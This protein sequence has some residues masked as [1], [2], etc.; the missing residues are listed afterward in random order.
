MR[1]KARTIYTRHL[2]I[3][4]LIILILSSIAY[5][6]NFYI[7]KYP[8]NDYM[9]ILVFTPSFFIALCFVGYELLY[10]LGKV[11]TQFIKE[12]VLYFITAL[13]IIYATNAVQYTPFPP[14]DRQIVTFEALFN[15][16]VDTIVSWTN[17]H[18]H[19][20]SLLNFSYEF[21]TFELFLLPIFVLIIH[22]YSYLREFCYLLLATCLFGFT[23]YYFFPT[24]APASIWPTGAFTLSQQATQ[25]K[26]WQIHHHIPPTTQ[27]GGM[28]SMPSFHIIWAWL[29]TYMVRFNAP[30]F[31][32]L[33]VYNSILTVACV[34][35]G[36]HY[37]LDIIGSVITIV[38][39]HW[40]YKK[41]TPHYNDH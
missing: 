38:L 19:L 15:I 35:L 37:P 7:T 1:H 31:Y 18:P 34:L 28:I 9:I 10:G 11:P 14:I 24:T 22:R 6:F 3:L 2:A 41:F 8:G 30:L 27:E 29:C 23:F 25:L 17:S 39:A 36:W 13:V 16:R 12:C 32:T 40:L 21:L 20:K 5:L 33:I 4:A 26:F